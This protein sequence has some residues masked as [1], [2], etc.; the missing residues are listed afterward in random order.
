MPTIVEILTDMSRIKFVL[1]GVEYKKSYITLGQGN[2]ANCE[3]LDE[4]RERRHV[5]RVQSVCSNKT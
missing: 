4:T 3:D 1:S 2:L 5:I